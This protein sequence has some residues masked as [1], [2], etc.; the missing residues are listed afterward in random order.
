MAGA[1]A[2][3]LRSLLCALLAFGALTPAAGRTLAFVN[4]VYRHGDRS[5]IV[6]YPTDP[7]TEKDWPQGFGQL[8]QIYVRSTNIDRTLMSAESNLAGLYPP[9]GQQI[10]HPGLKWQPIPVHTVPV[11]QDKIL[12][13][14]LKNCSRYTKLVEETENTDEY[15]KT[16]MENKDF[17]DML[18]KATGVPREQLSLEYAWSIYDT[19]FCEQLHH[20]TMP[21]WVTPSV[22]EHLR[23]LKEFHLQAIFGMYKQEEKSQLQGGLLVK[24]ILQNIEQSLK[25][26]PT[27]SPKLI[28]YSAHD[29]TIVAL[30]MALN[31]YS[32]APPYA[33]CHMV[34]LYKED[35]GTFTVEMY[36][37]N[38][39]SSAP[40]PLALPACSQSCPLDRFIEIVKGVI[41][42][43]WDK[44]CGH[45][46]NHFKI[47]LLLG[48][49]GS[50]CLLVLI[51]LAVWQYCCNWSQHEGYQKVSSGI[52][53]GKKMALM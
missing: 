17:L 51:F 2:A 10:F 4:L 50:F 3:G 7:N 1:A 52:E 49:A 25:V 32:Q 26:T 53:G 23:M 39:S 18:S 42:D 41:P 6:A 19:L 11:G 24:Q 30:Q 33:S 48:L 35:N 38:E 12:L 43:D 28:M 44:E 13:F 47:D 45:T 15:K 46:S 21:A 36:Y 22:M 20:K 31:I 37:K 8:T 34:E 29:T 27:L 16:L 14:P 5:P 40:Y 9:Q